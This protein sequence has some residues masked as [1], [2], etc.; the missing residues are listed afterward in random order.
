MWIGAPTSARS[1]SGTDRPVGGPASYLYRTDSIRWEADFGPVELVE[2]SGLTGE[3]PRWIRA[4]AV[5]V[6]PAQILPHGAVEPPAKP[7]PK[8]PSLLPRYI[9]L[10]KTSGN[11]EYWLVQWPQKVEFT[12]G[13]VTESMSFP[14]KRYPSELECRRAAWEYFDLRF[15]DLLTISPY[16]LGPVTIVNERAYHGAQRNRVFTVYPGFKPTVEA[17]LNKW[18]IAVWNPRTE[19]MTEPN[20]FCSNCALVRHT[21]GGIAQYVCNGHDVLKGA[22]YQAATQDFA[23]TLQLARRRYHQQRQNSGMS[24][25]RNRLRGKQ[26][27]PATGARERAPPIFQNLGGSSSSSSGERKP[28]KLQIVYPMLNGSDEQAR[29]FADTLGAVIR[30]DD[31]YGSD[32]G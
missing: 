11:N 6:K 20:E 14:V 21:G 3:Y 12:D 1:E 13:K 32:T 19:T 29:S 24:Q 17:K 26:S 16:G 18:S 4:V 2:D 31:A 7:V 22:A 30:T 23:N 27:P 8:D 25:A 10:T 28:E 9:S 15:R 5:G